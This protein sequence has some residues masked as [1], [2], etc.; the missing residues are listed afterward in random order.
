MHSRALLFSTIIL[1]GLSTA[2]P[3]ASQDRQDRGSAPQNNNGNKGNQGRP[4][5]PQ[6]KPNPGGGNARPQP[7][8]PNPGGGNQKPQPSRPQP[9]R[10]Q[11]SRPNPGRPN[12]SRPNPSRPNPGRPNPGRP[13]Q[14]RPSQGR[15]P[16]WGHRPSRRPSYSF[17]PNDRSYLRRYYLNRFA[18]INRANRPRFVIG[19]FFPYGYIP[20]LSPLP[21]DVYGYLPPPPPGYSMGYYDGYVVVY[22]PLTY[23]IAN[24]IDLL[25]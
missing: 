11:P 23:F 7:G 20:N 16:Q 25:Q 21:P 24:V 4:S 9:S 12:P 2:Y 15:P 10:P 1:F 18:A 5:G 8:R 13:S 19:G 17:R 14:G 3:A 22:D 6:T